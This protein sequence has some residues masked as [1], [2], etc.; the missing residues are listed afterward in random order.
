M[1]K[2]PKSIFVKGDVELKRYSDLSTRNYHHYYAVIKERS[3]ESV[4]EL[5]VRYGY[6][7]F[8]MLSAN[9]T[10]HYTGIDICDL[11]YAK[12]LLYN[13]FP[14]AMIT[15]IE[16]NS[17]EC[18]IDSSK[19]FDLVHVDGDHTLEGLRLDIALAHAH[20]KKTIFI[21]DYDY[22]PQVKQATDEFLAAHA[23]MKRKY[24]PSF[25]G[26]MVITL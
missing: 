19:K 21:H 3:V 13:N 15:F 24:I 20:A 18:D 8:A 26:I 14:N 6:S 25:R 10:M 7:A 12:R 16:K 11:K 2:I 23:S 17:H 4:L 22:L 9:P 5:G 1:Y